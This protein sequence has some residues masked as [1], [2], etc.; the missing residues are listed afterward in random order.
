[1]RRFCPIIRPP[2]RHGPEVTLVSAEVRRRLALGA[3]DFRSLDTRGNS[4]NDLLDYF[5]LQGEDILQSAVKRSAQRCAP[6]SALINCAVM[7]TLPPAF[8]TL[9]SRIWRT[10]SSHPTCLMSMILPL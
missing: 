2:E 4:S 9:P 1:M 5:I 8:R 3:F 7:R 10:P 6:V